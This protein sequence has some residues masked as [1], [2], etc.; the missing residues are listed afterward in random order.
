[1]VRSVARRSLPPHPKLV[2]TRADLTAASARRALGDVDVLFHLGFRMWREGSA[3]R[4][5]PANLSGTANVLAARPKRVVFA[6]SA[7]VYGAWPDNPLPLTEDAEPRPNPEVPYAV[8]KLEAER[9]CAEAAATAILR[10]C[11]VM[12]PHADP[13][14]RRSAAGYRLA[15]PAVPGVTQALQ[16]L[17][18]DDAAAA[19]HA[20]GRSPATGVF[21]VATADWMSEVDIARVAGGRV[22][23]LPLGVVLPASEVLARLRLLPFGADRSI[24]LNGPIAL[25][26]ARAAAGFGWSPTRTST[27]VLA[28]FV[29]RR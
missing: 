17:H 19:V 13:R 20:A 14:V 8:Q 11:A 28:D 29:R 4:L 16:F 27:Q 25:D 9:M 21:N 6:S 22:V 2:H 23:R 15:V 5:G 18:V 24:F 1:V 10:I 12:G 3:N 26:P 7:T